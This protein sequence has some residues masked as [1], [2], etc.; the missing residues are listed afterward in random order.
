MAVILEEKIPGPL[1]VAGVATFA[2]T[3]VVSGQ[4]QAQSGSAAAPSYAFSSDATTG[5][6]LIGASSMGVSAG[7]A[8]RLT[9][10]SAGATL[11]VPLL[12]TDNTLDIGATGAS[13]P[14]TG[15]FGTSVIVQNGSNST[16]FLSSANAQVASGGAF[17]F[18]SSASDA[19]G[20]PDVLLVRDAAN[21]LALANGATKPQ[22]L[23][24]YN[25]RTGA[26][27]GEWMELNWAATSNQ[28]IIRTAQSG[29][30]ARTLSIAYGGTTTLAI[31]VPIASTSTISI[32][33]A[34][35]GTSISGGRVAIPVASQNTSATS[36]THVELFV[37]NG[38]GPNPSS[39]ST[40]IYSAIKTAPTINYSAGTPGTGQIKII[41]IAPT[42]TAAP[43]G[44]NAAIT[45]SAS[46]SVIG[47]AQ[48][49]NQSDE[50]TNYEIARLAF[51]SNIFTIQCEKGGSGT[52]RGVN[53]C[54]SGGTLGFY[55]ATPVAR[56]AAITAPTSPGAVYSQAEAQ[57]M[58]VA[59][60]LI[61]TA[62]LNIGITL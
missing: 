9:L 15:Y 6:Y 39:T 29:G 25:T 41:H 26:G 8:V 53:V 3:V 17:G 60:N 45:L 16:L 52:V 31:Q 33:N 37:A 2:S 59:V 22:I 47:G 24:I 55:G 14:R 30:T 19:T 34:T 10:N 54:A 27:A 51:Q 21:V 13:R 48:F 46:A 1:S 43:T 20:T 35:Q 42:V 4:I 7:G 40:Q 5:M 28:A 58:E 23:R 11:A 57:S 32:G 18:T 36:G 38:G 44:L 62:L 49:H 50:A 61:R 56:A 12:F